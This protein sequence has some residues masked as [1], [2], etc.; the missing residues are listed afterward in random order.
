MDQP[1]IDE[2]LKIIRP[3]TSWQYAENLRKLYY[4][5]KEPIDRK[6]VELQIET[7]ISQLAK[8]S[9]DNEILL[10]PPEKKRCGGDIELGSVQYLG[11]KLFPYSIRLRDINRHAGI[12]GSTGSG[13][14]TIAANIIRE[15]RQ[16]KVP[17]IVIDWETSYRALAKTMKDFVVFTVGIDIN[18]LYLNLFDVPPGITHQEY[19]KSLITI[20]SNDYLGGQG[21]D[22]VL[23]EYILEAYQEKDNPLYEDLSEIIE[24]EIVRVLQVRGKLGGRSGLWK[25]TVLRQNK[26]MRTGCIGKVICSNRHT[27]IPNILDK[28]VVFE[29]GNLK[30]PHDRAFISH[31]I[32]NQLML[33]FQH[34]GIVTEELK[35]VVV[36]EEFHNLVNIQQSEGGGTPLLM[37]DT[38]FREIRKYG[39]GLIAIDQTPSQIPNAIF[40]NMN[41]KISFSLN[42]AKDTMAMARAMNMKEEDFD[43][44][45]MLRTG[46][47]VVSV[48]QTFSE[49]FVL[50]VPYK[51]PLQTV[52]DEELGALMGNISDLSVIVRSQNYDFATYT[53]SRQS[54]ISP[55]DEV[56]AYEK[57]LIHDIVERPFDG[58][59]ARTKRLGLHQTEMTKIHNDLSKKAIIHPITIDAKKLFDFTPHGKEK[60]KQLGIELKKQV[61]KGGLAHA[62]SVNKVVAHLKKL[63]LNPKIE[64]NNIDIADLDAGIGVEVETGKSN[65]LHNLKKL[66][67]AK[68]K[69]MYCLGVDK[70]AE[71]AVKR[72]TDFIENV[73]VMS[74]R[75]F[76]KLNKAQVISDQ[77]ELKNYET[78]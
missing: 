17:V 57:I 55:Q 74:V 15:L 25:E 7:L 72:L 1:R 67:A 49:P 58:V 60:L 12:F 36:M 77:T 28:W 37:I 71:I 10:P 31:F 78:K 22:T 44:L 4:M 62:Y 21:S 20:L 40:A 42:T 13:K 52:N 75:D 69:Y 38:L 5:Q 24:R 45:G 64:V 6:T 53:G 30:S 8:K 3:L 50:N 51:N 9:I 34:S 16:K 32:L 19:T 27:P 18:P 63:G 33:H 14:T 47:A 61:S 48:K 54:D 29:L 66:V 70:E 41:T 65:I 56:T 59:D 26:F 39:V 23:L 73:K 43:Y 2:L 68:L 35:L 76:V 46:E 11:K